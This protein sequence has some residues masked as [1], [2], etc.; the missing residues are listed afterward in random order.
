MARF[1]HRFFPTFH[2]TTMSSQPNGFLIKGLT[3]D[4]SP[5]RPSD[6]AERLCGVMSAFGSDG[7]MQ[8]SPYVYPISEAGLKCVVISVGLCEIEPM[9]YNFLVNFARDNEL[10]VI[11]G[12]IGQSG[13][14]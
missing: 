2:K 11:P 1:L 9:A 7:R 10:Q 12:T 8:Y 4:G 6:W 3:I 5:F 14:N 13:L